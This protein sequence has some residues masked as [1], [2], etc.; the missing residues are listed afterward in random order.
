MGEQASIFQ[1]GALDGARVDYPHT[2]PAA[3]RTTPISRG[4]I[5][6]SPMLGQGC[7]GG[8]CLTAFVTFDLHSTI[9]V[10]AFVTTQI[11]KLRV[12]LETNFASG[13]KNNVHEG[14]N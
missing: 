10:H 1:R 5:A 2:A 8:K 3:A 11:R 7:N 9:G 4:R 12:T 13:K 6:K 14:K